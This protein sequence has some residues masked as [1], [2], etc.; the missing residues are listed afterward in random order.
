[1]RKVKYTSAVASVLAIGCSQAAVAQVGADAPS[2][3]AA[4]SESGLAE[5]I[6]TAQR[7]AENAQKVPI[8]V[9]TV[10]ADVVKSL[11]ITNAEGLGQLLPG[12]TLNRQGQGVITYVRGVGSGSAIA[13]NEPSVA[14][15]IDDVYMPNASGA[16]FDF[17]SIEAVSVLKGP[18]GTLFGRNATGGVIQVKTKDPTAET[19]LDA[20]IGYANFDKISAAFY[21]ST[22]LAES[23]SA[24]IASYFNNQRDGW[25][26]NVL[27]G[28]DQFKNKSYGVRS[29]IKADLGDDTTVLLIGSY[30]K[31]ISDQGGIPGRV[32]PGTFGFR[33]YSP[34]ALGA[35]FYD[36]VI[37]VPAKTTVQSLSFSGKIEHDFGNATLKSITAYNDVK[38][39]LLAD[40]DASPTDLQDAVQ[41]Q[42]SRTFTQEFQLVSPS[43][44]PVQWILGAFY[45][46]DKSRV[47][48]HAY[49]I[50]LPTPFDAS[51][52][53]TT[54]SISG[55]G[56][57]TAEILPSLRATLGLRYTKD[58][59]EFD[60]QVISG[61]AVTSGPFTDDVTFKSLTGR[62]SLDYQV[63]PSVMTYIA[64]NKGFKSGV[65]NISAL[66][67]GSTAAPSPVSPE[68]LDAYSIGFKSEFLNRRVRFN[69][70]GYYYDYSNIQVSQVVGIATVLTNGGKATI[71]GVDAELTVLPVDR[72]TLSWTVSY[73]DGQYDDFR[74]GPQF[75]PQAPNSPI[76]IPAGCAFTTY[77]VGSS[78]AAGTSRPCNLSGN[79]TVQTSPFTS[80][81][82]AT[83]VIPTSV[84]EFR[85]LGSYY[86]GGKFYYEPDNNPN[87]RAPELDLFNSSVSWT[88]V[89]EKYG[90]NL[91]INN[92]TKEKYFNTVTENSTGGFRYG[93]A[94]PRTYGITAKL[95][96]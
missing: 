3:S 66:S 16:V 65:Y 80:T 46:R 44:L 79:K 47:Q 48:T 75:F 61:G 71:K 10:T 5:I 37:N 15:F 74:N 53:Q 77:P 41:R 82:T 2:E 23:V 21:A 49:G 11:G 51:G 86:H 13:G 70:E 92:I 40:L 72:L 25:G 43:G 76:A 31:R 19:K 30:D 50:A 26:T 83:Y 89:D 27:T 20:D 94:A 8:A 84:G 38:N 81:L 56:Q 73:A 68:S 32:L 90:I 52:Y 57:M 87:T 63:S 69:V 54:N 1:M 58:R 4:Q 55:F 14:M 62:A 6:V 36:S 67:L 35:G 85:L 29:K 33:G 34:E 78:G 39:Y 64:Y 59:R 24:N 18:Q 95:R 88:S 17:N 12:V 28:A 93:P 91:W 42:G 22:G 60:G 45:L 7:R 96:L 9:S